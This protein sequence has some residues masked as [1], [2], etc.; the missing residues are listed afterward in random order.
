MD[1][2][3]GFMM[4]RGI[5]KM[6]ETMQ[7]SGQ[8]AAEIVTAMLSFARKSE[9]VISSQSIGALL[10]QVLDLLQT[11]YDMKKH[12]DFKSVRIVRHPVYYSAAHAGQDAGFR[13][14]IC[15]YWR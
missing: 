4:D 15:L 10:D 13:Q 14:I 12:Y 7:Q 2:I 1:A 8:R 6:L 5:P 3:G 9:N 11:D